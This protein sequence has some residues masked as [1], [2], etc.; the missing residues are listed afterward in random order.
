MP[1][2]L[3]EAGD[4]F[5]IAIT[6]ALTFVLGL[7]REESGAREHGVVVAGVRTIPIIG[8]L[9]HGLALLSPEN[10]IQVVPG[11]AVVGAFL[12]VGYWFKCERE[13]F[14]ITS[15]ATALIGYVVGAMVAYRHTSEAAALTV[16][17]VLLL[18]GKQPLRQ[19]A[20]RLPAQ[21][22]TTFVTFLLLAGVILPVL[23]NQELTRFHF[24]PFQIWLVVVA[25]SGI[26]YASYLLQKVT[27]SEESLLLTALLGG[28]YSSTATTIA[29]ARRSVNDPDV[30]SYAGGMILASGTMYVRILILVW[31]FSSELGR[32]LAP[33]MVGLAL[34]GSG[35]GTAL[36]LLHT[37]PKTRKRPIDEEAQHPLAIGTAVVFA[38]LFLGLTVATQLTAQYLG[39]SGLMVLALV[40]GLTDIVPFILGLAASV[41][42]S[43]TPEVAIAAIMISIASNN[44][45]KG[46]YAIAL[47][48]RRAGALALAGLT[49]LAVLTVLAGT[50]L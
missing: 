30:R 29:L 12:V 20:A 22:I 16:A 32:R 24:N 26:S 50:L 25:V 45:V 10:S 43:V 39:N 46:L 1:D 11:F 3:H 9:G 18:T 15:E 47:G 21:E 14:G 33:E 31:T 13:R 35:A 37:H 17:T 4:I 38:A 6:L 36:I 44:V 8:L 41:G 40:V 2:Q 5:G 19:F 7:E 42:A 27:R 28:L 48:D 23:P 49:G 34:A